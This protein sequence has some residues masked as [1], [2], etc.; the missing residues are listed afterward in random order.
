MS[1]R[2]V[3]VVGASSGIGKAIAEAALDD[4]A[5]VVLA[6]R[7][8]ALLSEVA[9]SAASGT[10]TVTSCDVSKEHGCDELVSAVKSAISSIDLLVCAVGAAPL[11][12]LDHATDEDWATT[13]QTNL[14]G[15][16]RLI[17]A[18][19]P[20]LAPGAIVAVLSSENV[21]QARP[22]LGTY[23]ASKAA[24]DQMVETWR[25]EQPRVRF[26]RVVVGSTIDT[27]FGRAFTPDLLTWALPDW[28]ARGLLPENALVSADVSE[29]VV[30]A[31]ATVL[32]LPGVGLESLTV[33]PAGR[34]AGTSDAPGAIKVA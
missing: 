18:C 12:L 8:Q 13:L 9:D 5:S 17:R 25:A 29:A 24:L 32:A 6:A 23:S 27:E 1:G 11:A 3:V 20:L 21:G 28:Q 16:H 26:V 34:V 33:R 31:L 14:V 15:T 30:G 10:A 7:R 4:G 19:L 2:R 22:A